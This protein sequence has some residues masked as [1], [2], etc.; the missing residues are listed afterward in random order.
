[1]KPFKNYILYQCDLFNKLILNKSYSGKCRWHQTNSPM[2][3]SRYWTILF[4]QAVLPLLLLLVFTGSKAQFIFQKAL[5]TDGTDGT[6]D[7]IITIDG[8][9]VVMGYSAWGSVGNDGLY[10]A[11]IDTSGLVL[12][13]K[14]HYIIGGSGNYSAQTITETID[15]GFVVGSKTYNGVG[16]DGLLIKFNKQ[17]DTLFTKR[18]SITLGNNV[19]RVLQAPDGNLLALVDKNGLTSLVKMDN[20]FNLIGS[21]DALTPPSLRGIEIVGNKI[22]LL[23]NDSVNNL[24]IVDNNLTQIDTVTIPIDFPVYLKKSFDTTQ[25][26]V[27]GNN[28]GI[29]RMVYTDLL[30]NVNTICDS[31]FSIYK[32]DFNPVNVNNDWIFMG[33]YNNG[34]WGLDVQLYFTDECGTILHDTI[35]YRGSWTIQPLDE[36]GKKVLVDSQENYIIYGEARFGPL[37]ETDIFLFKYKKWNGFSTNIDENT[38]DLSNPANTILLYPNPFNNGFT[39]TG[40]SEPSEI[41]VMDVTGKVVYQTFIN[42]LS[43]NIS[44]NSWAKG[45]YVLQLK[46]L[47]NTTTLKVV[48]Q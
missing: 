26:I 36:F 37:G 5:G 13:E 10:L 48:K 47:Q 28:S 31:S 40:L 33:L 34:Q 21:I 16:D 46:G 41:L 3:C 7:L 20:N 11:K 45:M 25:L 19:G 22:Y 4:A 2:R 9:Y 12:W 17:G 32:D 44:A 43:T 1:M 30:G 14:W 39:L 42:N 8:N 6:R 27:E 23:K 35:L 15:S 18:D 24:L 29:R 38:V